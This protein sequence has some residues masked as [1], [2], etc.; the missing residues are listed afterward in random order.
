MEK[1]YDGHTCKRVGRWFEEH[2][3]EMIRDIKRL[4]RIPSISDPQSETGPF[5]KACRLVLDEMLAIGRE[6]GFYT[7]NKEYYVGTIG[8]EEK[9]WKNT[10][11]LWNHLDVVPLGEGWEY[12]PFQP[13][14]KDGYLIGRGAQDNKGPA[15]AMLYVMRCIRDLEL[16]MKHDICLFV[17]CDEERGMADLEYY[18]SR[19]PFPAL[20]MIADCGFP[21][22][23][24]E[25]GILEGWAAAECP[26]STDVVDL[27]G[28]SAGNIIPDRAVLVLR[29]RP[30]LEEQIRRL[31]ENLRTEREEGQ[32]R[33]TARGTSRHSAFPEGSVN[34][35]HE[36][37]KGVCCTGLLKEEDRRILR[38]IEKATS[39][40]YGEGIGIAYEDEVSGRLTC[41]GTVLKLQEGRAALQFNI[42]YSI[43]ADPVHMEAVL[44]GF[45]SAD[46]YR[47][48]RIRDSAPN[49][50]PKERKEV[51]CL[52]AL[53]NEMTGMDAKPYV[54]GGGTY[55]R[56][57]PNAFGYGIGGMPEREDDRAGSL[58]AKGHGGA[59]EPDEGLDLQKLLDGAKIYTMA[60][61]ALN[62]CELQD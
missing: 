49:Y 54:M 31:P 29:D 37:A 18:G 57:L 6:Y 11:G 28:G 10:I 9:D 51:A 2:R 25:K 1:G 20:S 30:E 34:A 3:E 44:S 24:G 7:E 42:R 41:A 4:V 36:L 43:S 22:C 12:E 45:C 52:T 27:Y 33:I 32:I 62:D 58:F 46:G 59:H 48:E 14:V 5:G 35:V 38:F 21:V 8:K 53:F 39:D 47:W 56:K 50:F 16:E 55:A 26:F 13:V 17:G 40:Y 19:Y 61:L 60:M 15:V 23:Y